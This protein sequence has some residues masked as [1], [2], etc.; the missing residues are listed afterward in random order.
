MDQ[1][2]INKLMAQCA[3]SNMPV[4]VRR[5][6]LTAIERESAM[7]TTGGAGES[8]STTSATSSGDTPTGRSDTNVKGDARATSDVDIEIQGIIYIYNPPARDK[9]GTGAL[10]EQLGMAQPETPAPANVSAAA[11]ATPV[12]GPAG[13]TVPA[14]AATGGLPAPAVP[15]AAAPTTPAVAPPRGPK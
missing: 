15:A 8:S 3:N 11:P 14:P 1:S 13:A 4:E 9:L 2:K 7:P 6:R 10:G 12:P 5:V